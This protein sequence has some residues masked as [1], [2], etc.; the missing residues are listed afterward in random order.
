MATHKSTKEKVIRF[1]K[2]GKTFREIQILI[3]QKIPKSTLSYW[4]AP[5]P[6]STQHQK[7]VQKIVQLNLAKA[8][9]RALSLQHERREKYY[10]D[11]YLKNQNLYVLLRQNKVGKLVLATLYLAEGGKT[12]H[13]SLMFGNSDPEIIVLFLKLLRQC[14]P[15][16]EN[17]FRC[18]IQC[19]ADQ[20]TRELQTFWSSITKVPLTQFYSPRIDPRT[21]GR[22]SRKKDYKGVCRIDYFSARI[23]HELKIIGKILV[24]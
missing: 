20:N 23:Y 9:K 3:R 21:I 15:I 22:T 2:Q 14:F 12:K 11:L 18:T 24:Q 19:R 17:K 7:R 1:R 16:D 10:A 5:Y 6:L 13:G 4:C 8:R